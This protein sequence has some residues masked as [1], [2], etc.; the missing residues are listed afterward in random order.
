[1]GHRQKGKGKKRSKAW[2]RGAG[3]A[4]LWKAAMRRWKRTERTSQ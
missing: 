4:R 3:E 1:M 2:H